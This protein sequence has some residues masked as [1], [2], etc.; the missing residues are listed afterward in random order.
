MIEYRL[1]GEETPTPEGTE[2]TPSKHAPEGEPKVEGETPTDGAQ[3][4]AA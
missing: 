4:P 3:T 2:E 1:D